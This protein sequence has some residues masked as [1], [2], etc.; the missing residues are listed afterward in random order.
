M[1]LEDWKDTVSLSATIATVINFLTGLQ[2]IRGY[3]RKGSAGDS[4]GLP[5]IVGSLNCAIWLKYGLLIDDWT[6]KV[7]NLIGTTLLASYSLAF[8]KYTPYKTSSIKQMV[9]AFGFFMTLS[10]YVDR[11]DED[12]EESRYILGIVGC[13]MGVGFFASPLASLAQVIRTRST[14]VLP[15]P[16]IVANF[17]VTSNW[18]LYGI[19][20]D[21]NFVLVPNALGWCL[22]MFQLLLFAYFPSKRKTS[23]PTSSS[24]TVPLLSM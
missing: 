11:M 9:F 14:E 18:W 23:L 21:D 3:V 1:V 5:F 15:F 19:I 13:A 8:Y 20:L 16:L 4:S 12:Q 6:I 24:D 22:A 10:F 17:F 7:V 2:V